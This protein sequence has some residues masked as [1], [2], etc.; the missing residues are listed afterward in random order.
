M[1]NIADHV[2]DN[3]NG[4]LVFGDVHGD[5]D[6]INRAYK[7]AKAHDMFFMS[8]GDLVDR[9]RMPFETVELMYNA[10]VDGEGGFVV[11][12]HDDKFHRYA[13]GA[14]VS[15]S[16]D[17]KRTLE[18]VGPEREEEFFKMYVG[19]IEYPVASS[20]YHKFDDIVLVHAAAHPG[21]WDNNGPITKTER[22]R[23]LVGETNNER[24]DD[25]YPVRLYNWIDCIPMG[26]TV[27]VGHDKQP[28][29]NTPITEPMTVS[30]SNGGKTV[31]L[32]TGCG[33]GGFLSAAIV[34]P[35]KSRKFEVTSFMSF[36]E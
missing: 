32:D 26:K 28:I 20:L 1:H 6:S 8:M 17:A 21:M 31:F 15:F 34:M 30:N 13:K 25:G 12:N 33:K 19:L 14:K 27:L 4:M 22:S 36:A 3:F 11:G 23:Y 18:D 29:N 35:N 5:F 16:V 7:Y 2:R 10:V 9:A 24:Y